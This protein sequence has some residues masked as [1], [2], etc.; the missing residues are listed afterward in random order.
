MHMHRTREIERRVVRCVSVNAHCA[1]DRHSYLLLPTAAW[2]AHPA[3][4]H[5]GLKDQEFSPGYGAGELV[6][7]VGCTVASGFAMRRAKCEGMPVFGFC[8]SQS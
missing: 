7:D 5:L 8:A 4:L 6:P 1:T 3:A 2:D